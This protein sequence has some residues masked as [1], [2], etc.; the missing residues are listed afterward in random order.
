MDDGVGGVQ[1][2]IDRALAG[3]RDVGVEGQ[4]LLGAVV[5][6]SVV[7]GDEVLG[8]EGR[9]LGADSSQDRDDLIDVALADRRVIATN[10]PHEVVAAGVVDALLVALVL[11][12][13]HIVVAVPAVLRPADEPRMVERDDDGRHLPVGQGT[14]LADALAVGLLVGVGVLYG[15]THGRGRVARAQVPILDGVISGLEQLF[16]DGSRGRDVVHVR[17]RDVVL[18]YAAYQFVVRL[19]HLPSFPKSML[20]FRVFYDEMPC[21]K[22]PSSLHITS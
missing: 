6:D 19:L 1:Y 20:A 7:H 16:L 9:R 13:P 18:G 17:S 21:L 2:E 12:H 11:V 5:V 4:E 14:E 8:D 10:E 22:R 3:E 15:R